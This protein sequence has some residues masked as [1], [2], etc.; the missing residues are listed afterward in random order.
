MIVNP[1]AGMGGR[2]GLKGTDGPEILD[3]AIELGATPVAPERAVE[4]LRTLRTR[5]TSSLELFTCSQK[6]GE[7][8]AKKAGFSPEVIDEAPGRR[9]T[10]DDT[11]RAA[12]GLRTCKVDLI[13]FV[14]G[15]G[16]ARDIC[17]AID[18]EIPCLGIPAGVKVYSSVFSTNPRTG[19]DLTASYL[20]GEARLTDAEVLDV[21]ESDFRMDRISVR[22]HGYLR[23][24]FH[25]L[26]LQN[27]KAGS[28][29]DEDE[30]SAQDAIAKFVEEELRDDR[31]YIIGPGSTT[32]ALGRCLGF[33]KT[34]LGVDAIRGRTLIGKDLSE[35][36]IIQL[37]GQD[38]ASI[39]VTP[40]G[41]Q[42]FIFGRGNPQ[43][44]AQVIRRVGKEN[45][46]VIATK[47]KVYSLKTKHLLVDTG[48]PELD[49]ELSGYMRTITG[50]REYSVL[51]VDG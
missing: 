46:I 30:V 41:G 39:I 42:G 47:R 16:T 32:A 33:E 6:M 40:I 4:A 19:G 1:I 9:T 36:D 3:R 34:M 22:L 21:D 18:Q 12:K 23:V 48:D 45:I 31:T 26:N 50:Y 25:P 15:D 38:R 20:E 49:K 8:S 7:E 17:E 29:V 51:H 44:S 11:E 5:L 10:A 2:V 14:G 24:P 37:L 27:S 13:L 35:Q 28:P 43:I